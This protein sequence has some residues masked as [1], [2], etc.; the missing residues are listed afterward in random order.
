MQERLA[1][2]DPHVRV[3]ARVRAR[4]SVR[5]RVKVTVAHVDPHVVAVLEL[6]ADS[7]RRL[8]PRAILAQ[9]A[10]T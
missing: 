10:L 4:V 8:D 9:H 7:S 6:V 2:V 3:K 5:V 1:V